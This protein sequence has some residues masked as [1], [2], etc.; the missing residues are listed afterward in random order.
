MNRA[1]DAPPRLARAAKAPPPAK[2][3]ALKWAAVPV[4][5]PPMSL[6]VFRQEFIVHAVRRVE[7]KR[8]S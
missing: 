8:L 2:E 3:E 1:N 6:F 5:F 7:I 4:C